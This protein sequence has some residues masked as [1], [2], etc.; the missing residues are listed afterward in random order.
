MWSGPRNLSTALMRS[1]ENRPD[2]VV[3]D[4]PLYAYYLRET[5]IDHPGRDEVLASQDSDWR[6][7]VDRL[8]GPVPHA[9][10][11][12]Y[13]KHMT[14]HLL[15]GVDRSR[16]RG[17]RHAFLIRHPC[18]VLASYA[19]VRAEPTVEDLGFPQQL[20]LFRS[21]GGPVLDARNLLTAPEPAL[22]ALCE[23]LGVPFCDRMLS[24]V[25]GPRESDGVWGRYWYD[26]VWRSTGFAPYRPPADPLPER[27]RPL[28]DACL[29][30]Y[31][32]LHAQRI[33]VPES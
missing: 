11:I 15:P 1:W 13:Q 16:L 10:R 12:F 9:A 14:H 27:L 20:E 22:R 33:T 5:G 30:Y 19:R 29:P 8:T 18:E 7:V 25:A 21:Y 28:L 4:E 23:H 24:W 2:T 17:L 31:D 6:R 32:E 26:A 3:W